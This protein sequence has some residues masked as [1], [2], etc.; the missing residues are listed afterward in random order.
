M[1]LDLINGPNLDRLGLRQPETYGRQ[2]L[3]ELYRRLDE[4]FP[5]VEWTRFQSNHE[6]DLVERLHQAHGHVDGVIINPGGLSHTS[7][8]LLDALLDVQVPVVEVHISQV[9]AR[10]EFRRKL[11][12]AQGCSA[13]ICGM[14]LHG[15]EAAARWLLQRAQEQAPCA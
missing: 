11:L 13:L 8:V 6:G 9:V 1:K 7:V 15:Y 12:T 4:A 10:E 14:G 2:G 5:H 3:H